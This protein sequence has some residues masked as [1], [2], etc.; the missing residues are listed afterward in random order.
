MPQFG[1]AQAVLQGP[2]LSPVPLLIDQQRE[3][4]LKAQLGDPGL[5]G[6]SAKGLRHSVQAQAMQLLQG[7]LIQHAFSSL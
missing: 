4:F 5:L 2:V 6:L 3:A 7:L 1:L